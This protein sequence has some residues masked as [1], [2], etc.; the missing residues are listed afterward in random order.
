M[1]YNG[2]ICKIGLVCYPPDIATILPWSESLDKPPVK[3]VFCIVNKIIS[4]VLVAH[5]LDCVEFTAY[6]I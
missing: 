6:W 2:I 1:A 4:I 3:I 5:C